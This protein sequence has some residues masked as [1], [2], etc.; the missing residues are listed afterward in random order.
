MAEADPWLREHP[1]ALEWVGAQFA[2][3]R[4][5]ADDPIVTTV[6][7]AY[8]SVTGEPAGIGGMR[9][10]ADMRLLV[11]QGGIPTVLFGPGDV[12]EAHRPDESVAVDDL[13]TATRVLVV[14]ALRFCGIGKN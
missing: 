13:L 6:A 9:F 8:R 1:P 7:T 12:R 11:N 14:S 4:I 10:G 3:A 2:P 5:R